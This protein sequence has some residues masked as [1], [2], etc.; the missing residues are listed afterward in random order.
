MDEPNALR[1]FRRE[2]RY[3]CAQAVLK[4]YAPLTG[5]DESCVDRFARFGGGRAPQGECGALY[6]AKAIFGDPAAK[7]SVE[8]QFVSAAGTTRCRD[9]RTSRRMSCDECVQTAAHAVFSHLTEHASLEPP[10]ECSA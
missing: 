8:Q 1:Y 5:C 7:Q 2:N 6:A 4:A 10:R 9:I 3:N